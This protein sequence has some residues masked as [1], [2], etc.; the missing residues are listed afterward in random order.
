M[1]GTA[2]SAKD[3]FEELED[4]AA[5]DDEAGEVLPPAQFAR[6]VVPVAFAPEEFARFARDARD[7]GLP[8]SQ[9]IRDAVLDHVA[10]DAP[11]RERR[12]PA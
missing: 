12:A 6:V 4:P 10:I 8:T 9:V 7:A 1:S 5:W 2:G 11:V 3:E